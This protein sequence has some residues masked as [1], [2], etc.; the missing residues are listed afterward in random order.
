MHCVKPLRGDKTHSGSPDLA[1]LRELLWLRDI[2]RLVGMQ[3]TLPGSIHAAGVLPQLV[4][5]GFG[6]VKLNL[7]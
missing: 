2:G 4:D 6:I 1:A 3:K 5:F 7:K